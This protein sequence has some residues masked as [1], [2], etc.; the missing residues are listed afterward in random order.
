MGNDLEPKQ[1]EQDNEPDLVRVKL[2]SAGYWK[3]LFTAV[4]GSPRTSL[5]FAAVA[6][7]ITPW[8][9][10]AAIVISIAWMY[11]VHFR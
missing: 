6:I 3:T 4:E 9:A 10:L 8:L 5:V 2:P 11:L 1:R 7:V